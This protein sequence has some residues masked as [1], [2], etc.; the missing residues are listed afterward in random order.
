MIEKI[1]AKRTEQNTA[2]CLKN[3]K[4]LAAK[5]PHP[6]SLEMTDFHVFRTLHKS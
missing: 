2:K 1:M 5:F 6:V 3:K 4:I